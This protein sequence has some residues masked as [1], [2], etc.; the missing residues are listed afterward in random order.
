VATDRL[1]RLVH[2]RGWSLDAEARVRLPPRTV[3]SNTSRRGGALGHCSNPFKQ[4]PD[5]SARETCPA[6]YPRLSPA[7]TDIWE[8]V[9]GSAARVRFLDEALPLSISGRFQRG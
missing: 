6:G 7:D 3:A 4:L 2:G 8:R 9:D 5:L 1:L